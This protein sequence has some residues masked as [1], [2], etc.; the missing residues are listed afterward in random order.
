MRYEAMP[1]GHD[2]GGNLGRALDPESVL[3]AAGLKPGQTI[4]DVGCGEGRFSLPAAAMVGQEGRVLAFD[5]S[6]ERVEALTRTAE[7]RGLDWIEAFV[8]DVTETIPMPSGM[9]DVCLVAN[10]LHGLVENNTVTTALAEIRR[11]LRLDGVLAIVEFKKN[12]RRPPGP[13]LSIR[14]SPE[15]LEAVLSQHGFELDSMTEVGS[16]HY[17]SLFSP[18]TA[19]G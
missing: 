2:F 19:E 15:E 4:L 11:L 13:P 12:M 6:E 14:L 5:S 17:L 3:K 16:F 7:E 8:A 9:V 1:S 18:A 10:V